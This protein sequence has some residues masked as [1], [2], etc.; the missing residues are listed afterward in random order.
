[1]Q[2]NQ[3]LT[4]LCQGSQVS[5]G[6]VGWI[7][8]ITDQTDQPLISLT[9]LSMIPLHGSGIRRLQHRLHMCFAVP[10][11]PPFQQLP[12]CMLPKYPWCLEPSGSILHCIYPC[13]GCQRGH[14]GYSSSWQGVFFFTVWPRLKVTTGYLIRRP[15]SWCPCNWNQHK[16]KHSR[17]ISLPSQ[18]SKTKSYSSSSPTE[19]HSNHSN[20]RASMTILSLLA[21]ASA[22]TALPLSSESNPKKNFVVNLLL[23]C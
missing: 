23:I 4:S 1:M 8:S 18:N 2:D 5:P 11:L 10:E 13:V 6:D 7:V 17:S 12:R 19:S 16:E 22:I 15:E 21:A 14:Q 9:E 3:S 20:M